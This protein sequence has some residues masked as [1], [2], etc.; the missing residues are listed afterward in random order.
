VDDY[1]YD[2][3]QVIIGDVDVDGYADVTCLHE[4]HDFVV[5]TLQKSLGGFQFERQPTVGVPG[6]V[7]AAGHVSSFVADFEGDGAPE[8]V[9]SHSVYLRP[10]K[11]TTSS[12]AASSACRSTST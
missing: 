7:A 2:V 10:A 4:G 8:L 6:F 1:Y 9:F 5:V 12:A 3:D 11:T